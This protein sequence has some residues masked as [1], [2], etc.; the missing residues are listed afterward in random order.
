MNDIEL[1]FKLGFKKGLEKISEQKNDDPPKNW[2][3][4]RKEVAKRKNSGAKWIGGGAGVAAASIH[5]LKSIKAKA[6]GAIAGLG[7]GLYGRSKRKSADKYN[8]KW[9]S[10]QGLSPTKKTIAL[11]WD[12]KTG[13]TTRLM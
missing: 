3:S 8:N 6:I 2:L 9:Y 10:R 7:L 11:N 5:G 12:P 1:A 13:K 4:M